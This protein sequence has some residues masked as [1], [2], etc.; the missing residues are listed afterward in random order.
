MTEE[1]KIE[2]KLI[3]R[4]IEKSQEKVEKHNFEIR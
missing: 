2:H 4:T 3:S 1:E